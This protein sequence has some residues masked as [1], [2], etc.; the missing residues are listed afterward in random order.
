MCQNGPRVTLHVSMTALIPLSAEPLPAVIRL[1]GQRS[2]FAGFR[3]FC[4]ELLR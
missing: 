3:T 2:G 4:Q 1:N